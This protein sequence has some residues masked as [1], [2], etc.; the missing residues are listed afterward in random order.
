MFFIATG[1]A[2]I[3]ISNLILRPHASNGAFKGSVQFHPASLRPEI[4]V[5]KWIMLAN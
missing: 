4:D 5:Q 1:K 2:L 3:A